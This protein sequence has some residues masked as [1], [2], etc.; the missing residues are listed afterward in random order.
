MEEY[1]RFLQ[2]LQDTPEPA[3][4]GT[5]LDNTV[6]LFGSASS[7]FHLSRNYPIVLTGGSNLGFKH[8]QY[9]KFGTDEDNSSSSGF[10][11]DAGWRSDVEEEERPLS[12]LY[13]TMLHRLGVDAESFGGSETTVAEV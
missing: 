7:A 12:D 1:G 11:T 3:G 10:S 8:G 6:T 2:R 9:L 5:M 13:L 4:N